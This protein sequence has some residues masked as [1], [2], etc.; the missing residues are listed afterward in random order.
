MSFSDDDT[1]VM[2]PNPLTDHEALLVQLSEMRKR[3]ELWRPIVETAKIV[4]GLWESER[5]LTP[6]VQSAFEM[7]ANMVHLA[8]K[9][10]GESDG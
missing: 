7:L 8:A 2:V 4:V 1:P 9:V 3:M 10:E 6:S 5:A